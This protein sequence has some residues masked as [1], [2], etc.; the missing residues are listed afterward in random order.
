M[1]NLG[2]GVFDGNEIEKLRKDGEFKILM[3]NSGYPTPEEE[4]GGGMT[5]ED[6]VET[7]HA[8]IDIYKGIKENPPSA[9]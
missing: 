8:L 1:E 7:G 4:S 5:P 6:F 2:K 9:Q 3:G